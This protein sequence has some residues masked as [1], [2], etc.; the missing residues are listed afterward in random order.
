MA[1]YGYRTLI[2]EK[3]FL[4]VRLR[5]RQ[6]MKDGSDLV[7]ILYKDRRLIFKTAS[8]TYGKKVI[9]TQIVEITDATIENIVNAKSFKDV[10]TLIK[11]SGLKIHCNCPAFQYWGFKYIAWKKGYGLEKEL[12]RPRVRNPRQYGYSCKHLYLVMSLY[13]FWSK[14]LAKKFKNWADDKVERNEGI[15]QI[16]R[17]RMNAVNREFVKGSNEETTSGSEIENEG[18]VGNILE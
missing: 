11:E 4:Q 15:N 8:G 7:A 10:E 3:S 12:R 18:D 9:W 13:P 6:L 17:A 5:A 16:Q 1:F 14:A 2:S